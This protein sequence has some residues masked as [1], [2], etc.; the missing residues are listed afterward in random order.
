LS[1]VCPLASYRSHRLFLLHS[2]GAACSFL[3]C[4]SFPLFSDP[5]GHAAHCCTVVSTLNFF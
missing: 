1:S 5:G 2:S 3:P 4:S